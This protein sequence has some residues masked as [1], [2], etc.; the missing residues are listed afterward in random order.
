MFIEV[1][2]IFSHNFYFLES[3][4]QSSRDLL[5]LNKYLLNKDEGFPGG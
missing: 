4:L 5:D 1:K 3:T 2:D